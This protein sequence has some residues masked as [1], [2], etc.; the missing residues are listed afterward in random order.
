MLKGRDIL[1]ISSI[2]WDFIWQ[3]HQEVMSILA[4]NGNRVLFVNSLS[5]RLP[6][7]TERSGRGSVWKKLR[8]YFKG[9]VRA[10]ENLYVVS[11][12]ALPFYGSRAVR[13]LNKYLVAAQVRWCMRRFGLEAPIVWLASA[14]AAGVT[15]RRF[16]ARLW[17]SALPPGEAA[18]RAGASVAW[19]GHGAQAARPD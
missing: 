16:V 1:C 9:A 15:G 4:R 10:E 12:L 14:E 19:E 2:D 8:S 17:D 6:K 11:P 18:E 7:L 3:G 5:T 13:W